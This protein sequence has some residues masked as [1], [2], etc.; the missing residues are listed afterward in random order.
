VIYPPE[1]LQYLKQFGKA[2]MQCCP[3]SDDIWLTVIALRG[4]FKIAQL[5]D[6]AAGFTAI[7]KTQ[8]KRLYDFNVLL[9]GNQIQL[10]KTFSKED[11]S[12]LWDH[13]QASEGRLIPERIVLKDRHAV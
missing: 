3:T 6:N 13:Q 10:T 12:T 5:K 8:M 1:Y 4:G 11:L 2:F 7:P 9:G